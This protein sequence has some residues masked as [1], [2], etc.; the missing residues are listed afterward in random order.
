LTLSLTNAIAELLARNL[1]E[2][3][4]KA[5]TVVA[6]KVPTASARTPLRC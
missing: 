2:A 1:G 5:P 3:H 6:E 4:H